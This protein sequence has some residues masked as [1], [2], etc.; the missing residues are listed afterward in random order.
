MKGRNLAC[1][2]ERNTPPVMNMAEEMVLVWK[3]VSMRN[4]PSFLAVPFSGS[5]LSNDRR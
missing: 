4:E 2:H 1:G 3:Q 5:E